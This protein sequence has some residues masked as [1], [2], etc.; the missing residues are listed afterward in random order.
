M[1]ITRMSLGGVPPF[2]KLIELRFDKR[3]NVF[4]GPNASGKSTILQMLAESLNGPEKNSGGLFRKVKFT[5]ERT[6]LRMM[7]STKSL[8]K[9]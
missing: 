3:V 5:F 9:I 8:V 1:H 4:I 6:L 2:T 7:N